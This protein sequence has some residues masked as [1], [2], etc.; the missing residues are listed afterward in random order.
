MQIFIAI[1]RFNNFIVENYQNLKFVL[2]I[3]PF[4]P[5][6]FCKQ[7]QNLD[8]EMMMIIWENEVCPTIWMRIQKHFPSSFY[9]N[10][11]SFMR[12]RCCDLKLYFFSKGRIWWPGEHFTT[13]QF[14]LFTY[15]FSLF[16]KLKSEN[17]K[18]FIMTTKLFIF[19]FQF[20]A[21]CKVN[22]VIL[23][24]ICITP[25]HCNI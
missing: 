21:V 24:S 11:F 18:R 14:T 1:N 15:H 22:D 20:F 17:V 4:F 16:I 19:T 2:K 10:L 6:R 12:L 5:N 13:L 23:Q 9:Q 3:S 7:F 8:S 25:W